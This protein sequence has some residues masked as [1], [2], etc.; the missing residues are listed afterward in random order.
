MHDKRVRALLLALLVAVSTTAA[1]QGYPS[2]P[3][4][5]VVPFPA[6][7]LPDQIARAMAP[8][9]QESLGQPFVIE[10]KP[11][12]IG[13]IGTAE[14]ARAAPD[15]HTIVMTTNSTLAAA[16]ALYKKL[17]Y[18]P[19][20][21]FAPIMLI[22]KT[23]MILLVRPDFPA[24]TLKDF[25]AL[26]RAKGGQLTGG[27][28]SAG[29]QVSIAKLKAGGGFAAVDVPYK[30]V[31][32]AVT[33]LLANQ[34][35]YTFAD[36]AVALGH[37]RGGKLRGL[38][39]TSAGR[40]P[41]APEIPAIAEEIPGYEVVLWY[42]LVAP[43]GTPREALQRIY[44]SAAGAMAKPEFKTRFTAFGVDPAPLG[45]G[46]FGDYIRREIDKWSRDIKQAG[47]QPE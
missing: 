21:D 15:G 44:E 43:A 36:F 5:F 10:N 20:K 24:Q 18:D 27:Y 4:R 33:D 17:A 34:I 35:G 22:S 38:G 32:P 42:G 31:P 47:I 28:G 9:L 39:V 25:L 37:I 6:G 45:P 19:V 23:S 13:T 41:L 14:A 11:G 3:V 46:E 26:A 30:G 29:S 1:A 7:A 8:Q 16:G 40:T 2:K 12:A